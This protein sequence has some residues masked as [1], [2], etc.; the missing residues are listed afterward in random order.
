MNVCMDV[1]MYVCVHGWM[2][3]CV[4]VC[5]MDGCMYVWMDVHVWMNACMN[6]CM[7]G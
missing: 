6:A 4:Y 7:Y 5:M 1:R 2:D 3:E